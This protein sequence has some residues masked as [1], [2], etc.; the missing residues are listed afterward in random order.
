MSV[1]K[2]YVTVDDAGTTCWYKDAKHSIRHRDGGPAIEYA[3]GCK[4]WWQNDQ[5]HRT[6][7]PAIEYADGSKS[8]WQ[9]DQLH[10]TDGP[11]IEYA[12]GHKEWWQ[13]D[14]LHRTDGPAIEW[15]NGTKEWWLNG[16]Q[17]TEAEFNQRV[18]YVGTS[19][20]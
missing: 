15:A 18:K 1:K 19:C 16:V 12:N 20:V 9:N 8:W 10:R 13:N 11:A 7:G 3:N 6:D 5:Y 2:Y 4:E 17:L 14:Q